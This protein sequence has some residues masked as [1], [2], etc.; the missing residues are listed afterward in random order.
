MIKNQPQTA[1]LD[2]WALGVL[3]YRLIVGHLPFEHSNLKRLFELIVKGKPKIPARVGKPA[4]DFIV[5]LLAVDP[6]KRLGAEPGRI[7]EHPYFEELDWNAVLRMEVEPDFVPEATR[8]DSVSNFDEVFTSESPQDS[9]TAD[10]GMISPVVNDFSYQNDD[11][12][13]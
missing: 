3:A 11:V 8:D 9:F 7:L 12:L 13:G 5:G 6:A 10:P 1:S 2:F 4:T